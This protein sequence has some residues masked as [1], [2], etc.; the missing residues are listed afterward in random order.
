MTRFWAILT[1]SVG[2]ASAPHAQEVW[3]CNQKNSVP[4]NRVENMV[5]PWAEN[6][7]TY[8]QGKVRVAL[9]SR[10]EHK[11]GAFYLLVLTE[12]GEGKG[13]RACWVVGHQPWEGYEAI[14]F[15]GIAPYHNG[16]NELILTFPVQGYNFEDPTKPVQRKLQVIINHK[17]NGMKA[18]YAD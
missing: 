4:I 2:L 16:A 7:R 15:Q 14:D 12:L 6:T 17:T 3:P 8:R 18:S 1:L 9:L 13:T 10:G 11:N 5:E